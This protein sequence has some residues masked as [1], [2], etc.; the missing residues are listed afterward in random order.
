MSYLTS[1]YDSGVLQRVTGES[2]T[3]N[4]LHFHSKNGYVLTNWTDS[5]Y[6]AVTTGKGILYYHHSWAVYESYFNT[7]TKLN[8]FWNLLATSTSSGNQTFVAFMEAKK[9]PFWTVQFHAEKNLYEWK[10]DA[11]RLTIDSIE[12]PQRLSQAF[13]EKAKRSPN[14]FLTTESLF[15]HLIYNYRSVAPPAKFDVQSFQEVYLFEEK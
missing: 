5:E 8:S 9:Y 10:V 6:N 3:V 2:P 14:R 13:V 7:H 12:V 4:T 1:G 15:K 11:P